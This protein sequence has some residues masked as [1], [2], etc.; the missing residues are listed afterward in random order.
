M[1]G[2]MLTKGSPCQGDRLVSRRPAMVSWF[3][4]VEV[5]HLVSRLTHGSV[6]VHIAE[7]A[8]EQQPNLHVGFVGIPAFT[9]RAPFRQCVHQQLALQ[10][11]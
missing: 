8:G 4:F 5:H 9:A 10:L 2:V 7:P 11:Q 3:C 6:Q 1:L